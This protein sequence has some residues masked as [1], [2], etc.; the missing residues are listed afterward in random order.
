MRVQ[1]IIIKD[2]AKLP[3]KV[4]CKKP[5]LMCIYRWIYSRFYC[6]SA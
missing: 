2:M 6:P 1:L 3:K 4:G 5:T